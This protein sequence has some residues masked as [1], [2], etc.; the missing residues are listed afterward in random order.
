MLATCLSPVALSQ[1]PNPDDAKKA[2]AASLVYASHIEAAHQALQ[3][4]SSKDVQEKLALTNPKLRGWE[5]DYLLS[6]SIKIG[7]EGHKSKQTLDGDGSRVESVAFTLDG[8]RLVIGSTNKGVKVW[9]FIKS[10]SLYLEGH[11][12]A[13]ASVAVSPDGKKFATGGWD[14]KVF[15]WDA[16]SGKKLMEYRGHNVPNTPPGDHQTTIVRSICFGPDSKQIVSVAF[17]NSQLVRHLSCEVKIWSVE[18]GETLTTLEGPHV[19]SRRFYITCANYSPNGKLIATGG[20]DKKIKLWDAKTGKELRAIQGHKNNVL[21]VGFSPDGK[22]IASASTDR[23]L[24]VWDVSTGKELLRL[25]GHK[26]PVF[27]V[28]FSH[29]GN[30]IVSGS[31]DKT[32]KLWNADTGVELFTLGNLSGPIVSVACSPDGK[33]IAAGG[34]APGRI[35]DAT[36]WDSIRIKK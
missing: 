13:A 20:Y 22:R 24:A 29:D 23:T 32:V 19:E 16:A 5:H 2:K 7:K 21:G 30:R 27:S 33:R 1:E 11:K 12:A 17:G 6:Q 4:G 31:W 9:D 10:E 35:A 36:V 18:T 15:I 14:G 28:K 25:K 26:G 34:G 8:R 3:R